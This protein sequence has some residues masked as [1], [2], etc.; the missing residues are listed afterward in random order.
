MLMFEL[1][2]R[3]ESQVAEKRGLSHCARGLHI[4]GPLERLSIRNCSVAA[5]VTRPEYPPRASTSRTIWPL[6]I[7]PTAGLQLIL[8]RPFKSGVSSKTEEPRLAAAIAASQPAWPPPTTMTSKRLFI[9]GFA[10]TDSNS[11]SHA[12]RQYRPP[13]GHRSR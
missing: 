6:A 1:L 4:A 9:P 12:L 8:A 2:S 7:P 11:P 5:S 13:Y 3:K 10:A